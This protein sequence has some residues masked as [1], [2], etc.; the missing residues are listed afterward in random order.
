MNNFCMFMHAD[1]IVIPATIF[2]HDVPQSST[3]FQLFSSSKDDAWSIFELG[4]MLFP[5]F[6]ADAET[7]R[8]LGLNISTVGF[9]TDYV[10][11]S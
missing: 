11:E 7:A 2:G 6:T 8:G 1:L 9:C 5:T 3:G 4:E 10:S